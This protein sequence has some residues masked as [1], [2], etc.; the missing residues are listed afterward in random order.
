MMHSGVK[1]PLS[2]VGYD[3]ITSGQ[4]FNISVN[5]GVWTGKEDKQKLASFRLNSSTEHSL[6][7]ASSMQTLWS[8]LYK[9]PLHS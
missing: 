9:D 4:H 1:A 5:S 3:K 6:V 7:K 8:D 2:A